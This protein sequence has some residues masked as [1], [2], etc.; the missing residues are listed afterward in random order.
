M[1][2]LFR[3]AS[4]P[5]R[6]IGCLV[7]NIGVYRDLDTVGNNRKVTCVADLKCTNEQTVKYD[8]ERTYSATHST[9]M[10]AFL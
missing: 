2:T 8:A 3:L 9:L 1:N 7:E 5:E 4:F 6:F 10:C